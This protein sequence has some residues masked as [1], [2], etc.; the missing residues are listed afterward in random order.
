MS[1]P[2]E[3]TYSPSISVALIPHRMTCMLC[4]RSNPTTAADRGLKHVME[5]GPWVQHCSLPNCS[6]ILRMSKIL[7]NNFPHRGVLRMTS[8]VSRKEKCESKYSVETHF[9]V[10]TEIC[11]NL[12]LIQITL[13]REE[14]FH[15]R[16]ERQ[17]RRLTIESPSGCP[18]P[19]SKNFRD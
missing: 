3:F 19:I 14:T 11:Q 10:S 15:T 17:H 9:Y 16:L 1:L 7:R 12:I 2:W 8:K 18:L 13:C 4:I 5:V 6:K